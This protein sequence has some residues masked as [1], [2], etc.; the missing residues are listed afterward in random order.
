MPTVHAAV[1]PPLAGAL[2][3]GWLAGGALPAA[4]GAELAAGVVHAAS[5]KTAINRN[6]ADLRIDIA[7]SP[8]VS[9][10]SPIESG[11]RLSLRTPCSRTVSRG[12]FGSTRWTADASFRSP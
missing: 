2:A 1:P 3:P 10:Q 5:M 11:A 6:A 9:C 8:H 12:L 7:D 4:V